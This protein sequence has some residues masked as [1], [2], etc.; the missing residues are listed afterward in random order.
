[1]PAFANATWH[2]V[3]KFDLTGGGRWSRNKQSEEQDTNGLLVGS[4]V[5]TGSSSDSVFTYALAPT[6]KPNANTRIYARIAK[7]YRPGGPNAVSPLASDAVPRTFGPDTTTNYEVG[8]KTETDD[9][10][11][12]LEAAAFII[13]W[14]NIQLL[15]QIDDLGVNANGGAAR[16][17][18]I[19]LTAGIEPQPF[20]VPLRQRLVRRLRI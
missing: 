12:S 9:H 13:D 19:E 16:S 17:K 3:P 7:G 5:F 1:M 6:F 2:I 8:V 20:L 11:L 15:A 4:S 18:G 14:K 10:L